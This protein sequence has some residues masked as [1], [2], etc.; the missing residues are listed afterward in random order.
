[1]PQHAHNAI[2]EHKS[3]EIYS[4]GFPGK[5]SVV[6]SLPANAGDAGF[7]P[8][9]G[10]GEGDGNL[11]QYPCLE[12]AVNRGAWRATVHGVTR[13]LDTTERLDKQ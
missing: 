6:K 7:N 3:S 9:V 4:R 10:N 5:E 1:M 12:N 8:W 11:L 13:E 2:R